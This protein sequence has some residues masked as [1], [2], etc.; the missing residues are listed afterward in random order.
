[1]PLLAAQ[2]L[3]SGLFFVW[4]SVTLA[5]LKFRVYPEC[6]SLEDLP[7]RSVHGSVCVHQVSAHQHVDGRCSH[8]SPLRASA[9]SNGRSADRG[10]HGA[11]HRIAQARPGDLR[12]DPRW[13][14]VPVRQGWL[15]VR[16]PGAPAPDREARL[17]SDR[18]ARRIVCGGPPRSPPACYYTAD[19][20]AS[21]RQIVE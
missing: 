8:R 5:R 21:F 16:Q 10:S 13:R 17:S 1:M 14:A 7:R 4:A 3:G 2:K 9:G 20:Y 19:H 18:G 12:T 15:G 11:C 6:A